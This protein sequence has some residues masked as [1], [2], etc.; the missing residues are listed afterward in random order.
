MSNGGKR[1][2]LPNEVASP[3]VREDL[4]LCFS[5]VSSSGKDF[6]CIPKCTG[7]FLLA[8]SFP[9]IIC[10]YSEEGI[11]SVRVGESKVSERWRDLETL[12]MLNGACIAWP[13]SARPIF[14]RSQL[15]E[16]LKNFNSVFR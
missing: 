14:I 1:T 15:M 9:G 4:I 10:S 16:L 7:K 13:H 5:A 11:E 3:A 12:G 2:C 8:K 6:E